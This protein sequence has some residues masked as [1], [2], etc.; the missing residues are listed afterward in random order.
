MLTANIQKEIDRDR[1]SDIDIETATE[2][3]RGK[4]NGNTI[5][6]AMTVAG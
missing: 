4:D 2:G 3:Q 6:R 5:L 1:D